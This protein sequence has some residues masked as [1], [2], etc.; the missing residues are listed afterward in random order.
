VVVNVELEYTSPII[1]NMKTI[2]V[3]IDEPTLERMDQLVSAR[4]R[5]KKQLSSGS[6]IS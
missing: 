5:G 2:A 1:A 6:T 3:T 4:T